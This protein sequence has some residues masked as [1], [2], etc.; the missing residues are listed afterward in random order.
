MRIL[1]VEEIPKDLW[2]D[3]KLHS[4]EELRVTYGEKLKEI[5]KY[6]LAVEGK[7]K[8]TAIHGGV[9]DDET[10]EHFIYRFPASCGRMEF[11]TISPNDVMAEISDSILS[12]FAQG[13]VS[14]LDIPG[15]TG[16]SMCSLLTTLAVLRTKDVVPKLPL[17]VRI[18]SGDFSPKANEI[19]T[20]MIAKIAPILSDL[21]ISV[22]HETM[23]WDATRN[24]HTAGLIDRWFNIS[25][26]NSEYVVCVSNFTGALIGA[27][28]LD[29]FKP[30]MSQIF[31]RLHDK[32]STI[33]WIEPASKSTSKLIGKLLKYLSSAIQW[34]KSSGKNDGFINSKYIMVN[35]LNNKEYPSSVEVQRF[36][37]TED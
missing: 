18:L 8:K 19:H 24:D 26:A 14:V 5:G 11:V 29:D 30:S 33:L 16:A 36:E 21:A 22:Q 7:P 13:E 23:L 20:E 6:E 12:T 31:A 32:T 25:K 37:R 15:G 1:P 27:G 34:F 35:P 17:T 9:T 3:G 28:I 4:P 2:C 10:M